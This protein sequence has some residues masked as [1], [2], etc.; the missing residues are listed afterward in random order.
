VKKNAKWEKWVQAIK[1]VNEDGS[2]WYPKGT[3]VYICS[4][5][6]ITGKPSSDPNNPDF[7]PS[8]FEPKSTG[9]EASNSQEERC[10]STSTMSSGQSADLGPSS[11]HQ[12]PSSNLPLYQSAPVT[13][14]V[15]YSST[16]GST[17]SS[18]IQHRPVV[19]GV[20]VGQSTAVIQ[21]TSTSSVPS[22]Y[23]RSV[24]LP[25]YQ[26]KYGELL[27]VIEDLGRE[28]K[29]TYAGSKMAQERLKKGIMHARTLVRECLLEVEKS[30]RQ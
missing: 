8:L 1:R 26:S 9:A 15:P 2:P 11:A 28:I 5:H 6:F 20:K 23:D 3:Y 22:K 27:N 10:I 4:D 24:S 21:K 18:A 25:T 12:K 13:V 7:I 29:P 14:H 17:P 16:I 19:Q 30:S